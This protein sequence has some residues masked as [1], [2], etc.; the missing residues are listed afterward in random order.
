[1]SAHADPDQDHG[2]ILQLS[3]QVEHEQTPAA[4][5][6][7][8]RRRWRSSDDTGDS[9]SGISLPGVAAS[10]LSSFKQ[11]LDRRGFRWHP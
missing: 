10:G 1:M 2:Q 8:A 11:A 3:D 4:A 7:L 6:L 9:T 5:E